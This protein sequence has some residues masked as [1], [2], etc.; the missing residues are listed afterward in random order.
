M[1]TIIALTLLLATLVIVIIT[2][3][4]I[5]NSKA[6]SKRQKANLIFGNILCPLLGSIVYYFCYKNKPDRK[7]I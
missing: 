6:L 1:E 2:I 4:D 3:Y 5:H 7:P